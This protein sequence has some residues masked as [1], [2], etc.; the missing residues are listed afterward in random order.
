MEDVKMTESAR[1]SVTDEKNKRVTNCYIEEALGLNALKI[2]IVIK[3]C[4][5]RL[6]SIRP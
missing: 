6:K 3:D 2:H 1:T 4:D 5:A